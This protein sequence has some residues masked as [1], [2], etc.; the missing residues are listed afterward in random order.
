M[1]SMYKSCIDSLMLAVGFSVPHNY[2]NHRLSLR[3]SVSVIILLEGPNWFRHRHSYLA[4]P[5]TTPSLGRVSTDLYLS[6]SSSDT[7]WSVWMWWSSCTG[8]SLRSH[9]TV[10]CGTPSNRHVSI[11]GEESVAS[12]DTRLIIWGGAEETKQKTR[13]IHKNNYCFAKCTVTPVKLCTLQL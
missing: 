3:C 10:G 4:T 8:L 1:D 9:S 13:N 7:A 11:W 12:E 6:G 5:L 2:V